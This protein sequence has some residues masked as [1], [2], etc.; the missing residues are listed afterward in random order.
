LTLT[1]FIDY[2]DAINGPLKL[3]YIQPPQSR[4][5][6]Q[7]LVSR[8]ELGKI[9]SG[10]RV[11]IQVEGYPVKEFG[12]LSGTVNY[13]SNLPTDKDSFLINISL[14]DG[15]NTN[16]KKVIF[17]RNNLDARAEIMTDSR[18]LFNRLWDGVRNAPKGR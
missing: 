4:Y 9:R 16:Y 14:P 13:I 15:L 8:T 2:P 10:Q 7:M 17:F 12:H 6:G 18:R 1:W 5:Y 11:M 3:L